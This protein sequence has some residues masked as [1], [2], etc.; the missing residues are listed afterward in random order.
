MRNSTIATARFSPSS[1]MAASSAWVAVLGRCGRRVDRARGLA[2]GGGGIW[3]RERIE[4][5]TDDEDCEED[6]EQHHH[7]ALL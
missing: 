2:G 4:E 1:G 7:A 5:E 6:S 3:N